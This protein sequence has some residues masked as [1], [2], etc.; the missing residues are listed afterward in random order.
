M[1]KKELVYI[2][3]K[4]CC[5][6]KEPLDKIDVNS[7]KESL[8]AFRVEVKKLRSF[9]SLLNLEMKKENYITLP[10]R[11]KNIYRLA[12]KIRDIQLH[13]QKL[14]KI[15]CKQAKYMFLL[16]QRMDKYSGRLKNNL[17]KKPIKNIHK[18]IVK[19]LPDLLEPE[20]VA[21]FFKQKSS[22]IN[23]LLSTPHRSDSVL[24]LIRKNIKDM[25]NICKIFQN[26]TRIPMSPKLWSETEIKDAEHFASELGLLNDARTT[27]SFLEPAYLKKT[28]RKERRALQKL[29]ATW[30]ADK[31]A[32]QKNLTIV[33]PFA[34]NR[35]SGAN[36]GN[37][38]SEA[39]EWN[40]QPHN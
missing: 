24:H 39:Y 22:R 17:Q 25:L 23:F 18:K 20:K 33:L 12:G 19:N 8:H 38:E 40:R 32:S 4:I 2:I 9:L 21:L 26:D 35:A 7:S 36:Q 29:R 6:L 14:K 31:T 10:K 27:L 16:H 11:L 37:Y 5:K 13:L 15:G 30:N 1:D 3:T 28:N 34:K